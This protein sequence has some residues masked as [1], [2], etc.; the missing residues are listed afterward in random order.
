M[1]GM[2]FHSASFSWKS[3]NAAHATHKFLYHNSSLT[4]REPHLKGGAGASCCWGWDFWSLG[5][6]SKKTGKF[7]SGHERWTHNTPET[8]SESRAAGS[9]AWF[10][11]PQMEPEPSSAAPG[12]TPRILVV[13]RNQPW[14]QSQSQLTCGALT[15]N[16]GTACWCC[17]IT[18]TVVSPPGFHI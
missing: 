4:P 16:G 10:I 7:S 11:Q 6:S 3:R 17:A 18:S 12:S 2:G 13:I 15:E 14:F 8:A 1:K 9:S 5:C